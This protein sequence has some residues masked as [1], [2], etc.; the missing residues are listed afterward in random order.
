MEKVIR[1]GKVAV[2]Y[3]PGFGAG[4][5]TW[6][7]SFPECLF[8]PD[9]VEIIESYTMNEPYDEE[10]EMTMRQKI[11]VTAEIKYG[12]EFYAG[13]ADDLRIMWLPKGTLFRVNEYDGSESI[14]TRDTIDWNVA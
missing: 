1:D 9:I 7:Y 8:D 10:S 11:V 4:W 2:L 12:E 5:S 13:G 14:E 3:S 6:N